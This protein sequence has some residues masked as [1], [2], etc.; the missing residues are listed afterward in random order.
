MKPISK[1]AQ[2]TFDKLIADMEP[3]TSKKLDNAPGCYMALSVERLTEDRF[4]MAHYFEQNGDLCPDPDMEFW[5]GPD[6]RIY[7]VSI[8]Q[9]FG[10]YRQVIHFDADGKPERFSPRG[11]RELS[12]FAAMWLKNIKSQQLSK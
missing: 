3:G 11:Q 7:P 1:A 9:A 10:G 2:K 5:R 6:G 4:S 8:T 12:S